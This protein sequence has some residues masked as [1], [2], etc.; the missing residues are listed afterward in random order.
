MLN[1][2]TNNLVLSSGMKKTKNPK[3]FLFE[4]YCSA[5]SAVS[6]EHSVIK[7][8]RQFPIEGHVAVLAVGKA[9]SA[10]MKGA[11]NV[12]SEQIGSALLITK[13]GHI[14]KTLDYPCLEAGHPIPNQQS[15]DAGVKM[16]TFLEN[17]P[18]NTQL[19]AL[20]S[21]GASA[22]VEVLP[23]NFDLHLLVKMNKWLLGSGL[24]IHEMNRI[25][26][27]VSLIKGGKLLNYLKQKKMIQLLISDV[28]GDD[29]NIIGSGLF[30]SD[31]SNT[32]S[33]DKVDL[34]SWLVP[35]VLP[36]PLIKDKTVKSYIVANNEM[37]CLDVVRRVKL[38]GFPVYYHGQ[39]LYGDVFELSG[40][41]AKNLDSAE[42][43]I[44]IWGGES[45]IILPDK[46]GCGGRNQ[47][48][49]LSLACH[50]ENI[51]GITVL[52]GATDGSDGATDDAGAIIDGF[53]LQRGAHCGLA[54]D[55]LLAA[56]AGT[57][58]AE[59]GDLLSTGPTGT[60]VMDVVIA[61]KEPI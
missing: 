31:F 46:I 40:M 21:G 42:T 11:E 2:T 43:G 28:K 1:L 37:A 4:I 7:Q 54:K 50:L 57:Y 5:L 13:T 36:Q 39:T 60:N 34:P 49:A 29:L 22:L 35:Y 9:A 58:L 47:S 32:N 41:L 33:V 8:L 61:L 45:S 55:Y 48:L 27:S 16:L 18:Q 3:D 59:S 23:D 51:K 12:L 14:D 19:V 52:V 24:T 30:A 44:H 6:G 53:T 10:M 17:I 20:I 26:Q 25:R 15:L 38:A 56:D